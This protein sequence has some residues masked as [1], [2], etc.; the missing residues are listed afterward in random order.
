M[1]IDLQAHRTT[2]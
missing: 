1:P 2:G